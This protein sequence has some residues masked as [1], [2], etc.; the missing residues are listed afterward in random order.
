MVSLQR[1]GTVITLY[2]DSGLMTS[3]VRIVA[4]EE[5][6]PLAVHW[7]LNVVCNTAGAFSACNA[8]ST[9]LFKVSKARSLRLRERRIGLQNSSNQVSNSI[10]EVVREWKPQQSK[11]D[12]RL[13]NKG[14]RTKSRH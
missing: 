3:C 4:L 8:Q 10:N 2:Y 13:G 7:S 1:F 6:R 12:R 5:V 9:I 11:L 14:Q